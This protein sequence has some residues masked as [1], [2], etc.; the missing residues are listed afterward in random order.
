[1]DGDKVEALAEKRIIHHST[2][3]LSKGWTAE[4]GPADFRDVGNE[5]LY[6]KESGT[7]S[8]Q[9]YLLQSPN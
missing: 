2:L 5:H 4:N 7:M 9:L 6:F 3:T 1:M 8:K